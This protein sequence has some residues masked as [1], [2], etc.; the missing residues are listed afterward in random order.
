MSSNIVRSVNEQSLL[1]R[2]GVGSEAKA[3]ASLESIKYNISRKP[4]RYLV[5]YWFNRSRNKIK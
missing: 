3:I 5:K 1:K 4:N 2:T